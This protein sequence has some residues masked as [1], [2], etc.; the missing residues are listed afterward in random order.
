VS[1]KV[2]A[3][4][5]GVLDRSFETP[6]ANPAAESLISRMWTAEG[7]LCVAAVVDLFPRPAVGWSDNA[8][9]GSD[10]Y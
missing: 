9:R 6:A 4:A 3:V 7:W 2:A 5:P 8:G 1:G 10:A